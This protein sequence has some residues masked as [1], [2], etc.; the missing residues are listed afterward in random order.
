M[1]SYKAGKPIVIIMLV[2][3]IMTSI[4]FI[5]VQPIVFIL[6]LLSYDDSSAR[7]RYNLDINY[8]ERI[9]LRSEKVTAVYQGIKYENLDN[10]FREYYSE[11]HKT[12]DNTSSSAYFVSKS[13]SFF[14]CVSDGNYT[15]K[16]IYKNNNQSFVLYCVADSY[17]NFADRNFDELK[18]VN[19]KGATYK[20]NSAAYFNNLVSYFV[21]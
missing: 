15:Y 7:Y 4:A 10:G 5:L 9:I 16:A 12:P 6:Y 17:S 3:A 8:Y 13:D 19:K 2:I 14:V 20:Y 11:S 1:N 18:Y 21:Q